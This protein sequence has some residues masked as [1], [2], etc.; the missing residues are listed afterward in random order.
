MKNVC[1]VQARTTSTRFPEKIFSSF[2]G[3]T[4]LDYLLCKISNSGIVNKLILAVP[5]SQKQIFANRLKGNHYSS[6]FAIFGG[7]EENLI[8]RYYN[9]YKSLAP[10]ADY[11]IRITSDCPLVNMDILKAMVEFYESNAIQGYFCNTN[12]KDCL[13][14]GLD[15]EIFDTNSLYRITKIQDSEKKEHIAY[16]FGKQENFLGFSTIGA[17]NDIELS[18]DVP[19][20]INFLE[21]FYVTDEDLLSKLNID[22]TKKDI[23]LRKYDH[24]VHENGRKRRL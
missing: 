3:T 8:L 22:L 24:S 13:P 2:K 4:V 7:S 14:S 19:E 6:N 20:D 23:R 12:F 11:I 5:V 15:I 18:I 10:N 21:S 17:S 16:A 9:A 1:I